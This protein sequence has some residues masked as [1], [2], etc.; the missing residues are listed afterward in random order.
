MHNDY[1][2]FMGATE[3]ERKWRWLWWA[4]PIVV[5]AG[6]AGALYYGRTHQEQAVAR[7]DPPAPAA[8][9]PEELP[10]RNV[11][12]RPAS[13]ETAPL[14]PLGS[15]DAELSDALAGI[16]ERPLESVLVPKDIVRHLVVTIDNLPRKKYAAQMW[17][18]KPTPGEFAVSSE[19][20]VALSAD[21]YARYE[22]IMAL[23]KNTDATSVAALYK[24]YYPLFQQAYVELGY[25]DGYFNDRLIEVIDHL[26]ETPE[27]QGPILLTQP[28]VFYEF[29]DPELEQRSAGQKTLIRMGSRNAALI[30]LKLRELRREV[31]VRN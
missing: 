2:D 31:A 11:I 8:S 14:P 19:D 16:F 6:L 7:Q 12:E 20:A 9:S 15:S 25:P 21:N 23:L 1:D 4:V 13:A 10:Q 27:V 28:R 17:P 22:P 29:A 30:K 26:L 5:A 18:V 3:A 24:R